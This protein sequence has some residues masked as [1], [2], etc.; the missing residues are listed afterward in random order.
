MERAQAEALIQQQI[1]PQILQD[2]P[3]GSIFMQFARKLP[4]MT[5]NQTTMRVLDT[6]PLA[7]FVN[8]D[9]GFKGVSTAAW[10]N[11]FIH[12]EELAV[13]IPIPEAVLADASYDIIGEVKPRIIE[14][15]NDRV[16]QAIIYDIGKPRLWPQGIISQARNAGNAV[17]PE[18][19][20]MTL[21]LVKTAF[22]PR[23][24]KRAMRLTAWFPTLP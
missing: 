18:K 17:P 15:I 1:A 7:Y 24:K 3:Q 9:T 21:S 10:D 12:A 20:C 6:L 5:S 2:T 16:D 11:V 22:L 19:I 8:G 14:A 4:N 23:W 13:I